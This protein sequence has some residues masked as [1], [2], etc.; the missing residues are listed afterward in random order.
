MG[1][2]SGSGTDKCTPWRQCPHSVK[3]PCPSS[4][5]LISKHPTA[6]PKDSLVIP[7]SGS[8]SKLGFYFKRAQEPH[9][10]PKETCIT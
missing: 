4:F 6:P 7:G 8:P 1:V 9:P 2:T 10:H 5:F 3:P